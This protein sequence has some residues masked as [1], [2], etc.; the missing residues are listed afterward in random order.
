MAYHGKVG[1]F[2]YGTLG[3]PVVA[4]QIPKAKA[5]DGGESLGCVRGCLRLL[6]LPCYAHNLFALLEAHGCLCRTHACCF[7]FLDAR[8]KALVRGQDDCGATG[9]FKEESADGFLEDGISLGKA[10]LDACKG[11]FPC[12]GVQGIFVVEPGGKAL[13]HG[14]KAL[15]KVSGIAL[16]VAELNSVHCCFNKGFVYALLGQLLQ[17]REYELFGPWKI[18]FGHTLEASGIACLGKIH[19]QAVA[20]GVLAKARAYERAAQG[21]A[22]H[23]FQ[24]VLQHLQGQ[25][26]FQIPALACE[27]VHGKEALCALFCRI[28][29]CHAGRGR[30][31]RLEGNGRIHV[32][33]PLAGKGPCHYCQALFFRIVSPEEEAGVGGMVVAAVEVPEFLVAE[34][35]NFVRAA[36][37]V[38][39]VEGVREDGVL[40][41]LAQT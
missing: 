26:A 8:G 21:R 29:P 28:G 6:K 15:R 24:N 3:Q 30:K 16:A 31:G 4:G 13:Q 10:L 32:A 17:C 19:L 39:T 20:S 40:A 5:W 37:A 23:A 34:R 41:F 7:L 14:G 36:A 25:R 27:P 11:L 35:G 2:L 38:Q 12:Q 9:V 1:S 22:W 18:F 33:V